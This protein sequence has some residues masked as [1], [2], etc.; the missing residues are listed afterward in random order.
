[1]PA[2]QSPS[3]S[4]KW[5]APEGVPI[6]AFIFGGRRA[7]VA[8]LVYESFDWQ[9]GVFVGSTMASETTAAATGDVGVTRRDPMAMLP[10]CGYNM[11]DYFGHWLEMGKKI[12]K[13]PKIFHVNWFRK[14]ANGKF[15]WPGYG[16]NVRVLKW[17]LERVE[18]R[19]A[20]QETPIGYVPA[21]GGLTLD[22]LKIPSDALDELLR[23]NP[24]DWENEMDD[25]KQFLSKFGARLPKEIREEQE[26]LV[27]RFGRLAGVAR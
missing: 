22:G 8:P 15:L 11:A 6:S 18:G 24:A 2:K 23:V 13:P 7:R 1:V 17:I 5:E 3:I 4:P 26:K 20:A 9:H 12:P 21:K 25:S 16:E 14:G 19:G 27:R 10:F